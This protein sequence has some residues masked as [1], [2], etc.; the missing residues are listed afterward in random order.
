MTLP[1]ICFSHGQD[2]GP[3][4]TKISAMAEAAQRR[5]FLVES[6]D[7]TALS[8]PAERVRKLVEFC[9]SLPLPPALVGSSMGGHVAAAASGQVRVLGLF[10]IA[11]AFY[12]PGYE[13]LT[14]VS[15]CARVSI[16]HGWSDEVVP[17]RN[18]IRWARE[19]G[20]ELHVIP[21]DHRLTARLDRVLTL[22]DDFLSDLAGT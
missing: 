19:H 2:S 10:L 17:A 15:G 13:D 14:P 22:F 8:D 4:G 16:V 1:L 12:M 3:W 11:P 9:D 7:Y 6:L 20:A 18:S 21:G 5:G